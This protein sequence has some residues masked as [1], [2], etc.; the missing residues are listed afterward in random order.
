MRSPLLP[1]PWSQL[2]L[3][4][5]PTWGAWAEHQ[6]SLPLSQAHPLTFVFG[7]NDNGNVNLDNITLEPDPGVIRR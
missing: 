6:V 3:P 2:R 7:P 4:T 1:H 5:L